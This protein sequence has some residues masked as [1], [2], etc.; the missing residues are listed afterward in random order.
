MYVSMHQAVIKAVFS[1][2]ESVIDVLRASPAANI[3]EFQQPLN[4]FT[5]QLI[6]WFPNN[7]TPRHH[8]RGFQAR[9]G[10]DRSR[11]VVPS[12]FLYLYIRAARPAIMHGYPKCIAVRTF[13]RIDFGHLCV[14]QAP[15]S[16]TARSRHSQYNPPALSSPYHRTL[17][18]GLPT[19]PVVSLYFDLFRT[20]PYR[21][22]F[23]SLP[24]DLDLL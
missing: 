5:C 16:P 8:A 4:A 7:V 13:E 14:Y 20:P 21:S 6:F 1:T 3:A 23:N 19:I 10:S 11:S 15:F 9:Q 17:H 18:C 12:N 22:S 24:T 2:C